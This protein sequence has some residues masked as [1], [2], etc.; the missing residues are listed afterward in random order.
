MK[1]DS[2]YLKHILKAI[3]KIEN[4]IVD[5]KFI[6]MSNDEMLTSALAYQLSIIGEAANNLSEEFKKEH[7]EI[8]FRDIISMRNLLIHKY[9]G[10]K[11][12]IIWDTCKNDL[13][14]LKK[15]IKK[16]L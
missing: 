8:S 16:Y 11:R 1:K 7:A 4:F 15:I 6:D 13:R 2:I 5:K 3:N 14:D 12:K 9:F 10:I